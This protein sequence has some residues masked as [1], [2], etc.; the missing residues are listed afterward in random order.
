M[1]PLT[2]GD[3]TV[4]AVVE[5]SGPRIPAAMLLPAAE[6]T[7][8]EAH[9]P[10]MTPD[11]YVPATHMFSMVRQAYVVRTAHHTILIDTCVGEHKDR[12]NERFRLTETPWPANFNAL[13]I[14]YDDIDIVMCTH[15]HVDHV[16]WNTRLEDG[17]WVPTFPNARYLFGKTEMETYRAAIAEAP[18]PDGPIYA[19]SILPVIE[20]GQAEIVADDFELSDGLW[21]EMTPGH[22]E[23]HICIHLQNTGGHAVFSGDLMHHPI[24]VREPQWN[25]CFCGDDAQARITRRSFLEQHA[26]TDTLIVPSHFERGTVGRLESLADGFTFNFRDGGSTHAPP[27]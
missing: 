10:W 16:G 20:A 8:I 12:T 11:L 17:R 27:G 22:T 2:V 3:V 13:G 23:G 4:E 14:T 7:E 21:F 18:D 25:S 6:R 24:Q 19:D 1:R 15:L 9:I 26:D 5:V